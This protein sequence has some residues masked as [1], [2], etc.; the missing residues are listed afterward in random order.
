MV[1]RVLG[2]FLRGNALK[3][4]SFNNY[5]SVFYFFLYFGKIFKYAWPIEKPPGLF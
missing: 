3:G 2:A 1:R 5:I 4:D